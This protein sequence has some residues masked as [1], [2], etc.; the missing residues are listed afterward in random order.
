MWVH[1]VA[2]SSEK[3]ICSE[4]GEKYAWVKHRLQPKTGL[5]KYVG[6]F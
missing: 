6:G 4:S 1:N 3:A 2:S 5:N